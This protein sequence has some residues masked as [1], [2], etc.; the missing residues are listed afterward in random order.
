MG[1]DAHVVVVGPEHLAEHAERRVAELER[2]WTR[3]DARSEVSAL[4]S[5]SIPASGLSSGQASPRSRRS[6]L[7][8]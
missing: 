3:F 4:P 1:S 2:R 7:P 8:S 5:E 6:R